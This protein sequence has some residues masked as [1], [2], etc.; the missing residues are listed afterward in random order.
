MFHVKRPTRRWLLAPLIVAIPILTACAGISND[1]DGWAAPLVVDH[2]QFDNVVVIRTDRAHIAAVNLDTNIALWEFPDGQGSFPGLL[3]QIDA[4]GFYGT[5]ALSGNGEELLVGDHDEGLVYAVRVDGTSARLLFD[6]RD[7][8]IGGIVVD[9]D[10]RSVYIPTSDRRI[11][12]V[13]IDN[14][15]PNRDGARWIFSGVGNEIWGTPSL[16]DSATH[17]RLLLVP[18]MDG[19]LY[20]LQR[21][22]V[23][24][25]EP[26]VA[27]VFK[28][29]GA[30]AGNAVV[31]QNIAYVG[32]FDNRF[33]AID[34]ETG[35][36]IWSQA[37]DGWFWTTAL[38]D[39]GT[40]YA[41]DMQGSLW[42]W[43]ASDGRLQEGYPY[44]VGDPVRAKPI[45]SEDRATMIIVTR[46]KQIHVIEPTNGAAFRRVVEDELKLPNR[47]LADPVLLDGKILVNDDRGQLLEIASTVEIPTGG[48][49]FTNITPAAGS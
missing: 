16:A 14:P 17:G 29:G 39:Q 13:D 47:V 5:P 44:D 18:S 1:P 8:I 32:S 7:K 38:I 9:E 3:E 30:I 2:P 43:D 15:P 42:A 48:K 28:T 25:G 34:V 45:F 24:D 26:G 35:Q 49:A 19:N 31:V 36:E 11:Y 22:N 40:V 23:T 6:T 10:G 27:W 41:A 12:A 21:D 4:R 33:Y 46:G 20:A 37:G